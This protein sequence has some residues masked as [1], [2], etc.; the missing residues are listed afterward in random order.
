MW[1]WWLETHFQF[2]RR[3]DCHNNK[4][5]WLSLELQSS[6][7]MIMTFKFIDFVSGWAL[8][9]KSSHPNCVIKNK[10]FPNRN[11]IM[12][13][14]IGGLWD[15]IFHWWKYWLNAEMMD[16]FLNQIY[17]NSYNLSMFGFWL[18]EGFH[19]HLKQIDLFLLWQDISVPEGFIDIFEDLS[20]RAT[21]NVL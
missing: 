2:W 9:N 1:W 19:H 17:C 11:F 5:Q 8:V 6:P 21:L 20:S 3:L 15:Q 10:I 12:Q 16:H 4:H 7:Q 18:K 14:R 13:L